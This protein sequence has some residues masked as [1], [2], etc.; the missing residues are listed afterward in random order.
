MSNDKLQ[1][2][3]EQTWSDL[4]KATDQV[5]HPWRL[6][7][8]G[9][10]GLNG[11]EVRTVVLRSVDPV[12]RQLITQTDV[13]STKVP[14][15][16]KDPRVA[17]HFFNPQTNVQV[18][19]NGRVT[20]HH[21][22]EVTRTVWVA[23]P[24]ANKRNYATSSAPGLPVDDP[25]LGQVQ[26]DA[27]TAAYANFTVLSAEITFIDWLQLGEELHRRAQFKWTGSDWRGAWVIP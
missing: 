12:T 16:R 17:W 23:V 2:I 24:E 11:P 4:T 26:L 1:T 6:P 18:R 13:R 7:A 9:T 8:M 20:V 25:A 21:D 22:D 19:A 27:F 14:G 5:D 3:L 15:F 10:H